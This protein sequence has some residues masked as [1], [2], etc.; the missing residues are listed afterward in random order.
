LPLPVQHV[1]FWAQTAAMHASPQRGIFF[2]IA[3]G[4]WLGLAL[5]QAPGKAVVPVVQHPGCVAHTPAAH[6]SQ[7]SAS[8]A[9]PA[10]HKPCA[11][12]PPTVGAQHVGCAAQMLVTQLS[13][14]LASAAPA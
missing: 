8:R 1:E 14:A 13:H 11:Q 4:P 12:L 7:P 2:P 6:A 10:V 5:T 3:H 9:P